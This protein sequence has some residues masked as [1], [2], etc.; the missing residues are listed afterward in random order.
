MATPSLPPDG[1]P[2]AVRP[3]P[4][5]GNP[6]AYDAVLCPACGTALNRRSGPDVAI[7]AAVVLAVA[8]AVLLAVLVARGGGSSSPASAPATPTVVGATATTAPATTAPA[9]TP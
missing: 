5:C 8:V 1:T 3:C 4:V 6:V 2:V 9:P 7:V